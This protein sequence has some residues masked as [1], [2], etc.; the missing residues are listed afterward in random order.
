MGGECGALTNF[1]L[2]A[3]FIIK[4]PAGMFFFSELE[5]KRV[6]TAE[7]RCQGAEVCCFDSLL[8]SS[9]VLWADRVSEQVIDEAA[10]Q[11]DRMVCDREECSVT[12]AVIWFCTSPKSTFYGDCEYCCS[13]LPYPCPLPPQIH[14]S[15][16][17][18]TQEMCQLFY[19]LAPY[20]F[21]LCKA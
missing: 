13:P 2:M 20:F 18:S 6:R 14:L 19:S 9:N 15:P 1:L 16:P 12:G 7:D 8:S 3:H 17:R 5:A 4:P 21:I 10:I 11:R